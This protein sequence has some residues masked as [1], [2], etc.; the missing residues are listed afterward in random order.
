MF[1]VRVVVA[2]KLV[3]NSRVHLEGA[4]LSLPEGARVRDLLMEVGVSDGEVKQ[5]TVNGRRG[6]LDQSLRRNDVVELRG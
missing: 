4:D 1:R 6:R 2:G 3:N 5:V